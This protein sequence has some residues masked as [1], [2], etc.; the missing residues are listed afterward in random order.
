[1]LGPVLR[2]NAA[3]AAPLY[4]D[5]LDCIAP[6]HPGA[7]SGQRAQA[8]IAT[9]LDLCASTGLPLHL[10]EIGISQADLP[11][12]AAESQ[13]QQRLLVNNPVP[14]SEGDAARL[15]AEAL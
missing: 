7:G 11:L 8:F 13:K 4:A 3:A 6:G 14:I 15:Y 1:M 2:F 10:A 9:L 12:L 5:L